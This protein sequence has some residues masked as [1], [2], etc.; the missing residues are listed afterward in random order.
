MRLIPPLT[1]YKF[2]NSSLGDGP[3]PVTTTQG[4]KPILLTSHLDYVAI[5]LTQSI[6][7]VGR[8]DLAFLNYLKRN[9]F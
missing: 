6:G 2:S 7:W 5:R 3:S 1:R 9:I 4:D 8:K